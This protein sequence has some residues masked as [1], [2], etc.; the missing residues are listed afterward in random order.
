MFDYL[1]SAVDYLMQFKPT[2][3]YDIAGMKIGEESVLSE[4]GYSYVYLAHNRNNYAKKFALKKIIVQDRV[5]EEAVM[6]EV[7]LW[8]ELG[9]HPNIWKYY[10]HT[11]I[12]GDNAKTVVILCE[13]W[14]GGTLVDLIT[15]NKYKL[16]EEQIIYVLTQ[17]ARGLKYMHEHDPP[18]AH[19]DIKVENILMEDQVFKLADFGS[20]STDTLN[21][22][23][24]SK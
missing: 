24:D 3:V 8:S 23:K 4:G 19:R 7:E 14:S 16:V 1:N 13:Y 18:I 20:C 10:G 15:R 2:T 11:E 17:V 5:N 9:D 22:N 12:E 21:Y 6:R